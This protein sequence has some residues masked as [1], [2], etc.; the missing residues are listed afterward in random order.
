MTKNG[1]YLIDPDKDKN[2][3][4]TYAGAH[5]HYLNKNKRFADELKIIGPTTTKLKIM[6]R[7]NNTMSSESFIGLF[8]SRKWE[9]RFL[10]NFI[11]F[12][13]CNRAPKTLF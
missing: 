4:I 3:Q 8:V 7:M 2:V 1:D 13:V 11:L 6:V 10:K 9:E 5:I 12:S